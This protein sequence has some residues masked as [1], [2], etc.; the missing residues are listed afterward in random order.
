MNQT[1]MVLNHL[2]EKKSIT[3]L[4]AMEC[5]GIARLA[6]RINDLH[7][8]G[9]PVKKVMEKGKN[10]YG[11]PTSYARYYLKEERNA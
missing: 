5:Y 2:R 7:T 10:R 9:F 11:K 3:Q 4:E 6:S 1:E 8:L